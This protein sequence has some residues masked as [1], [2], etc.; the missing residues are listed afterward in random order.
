MPRSWTS[1]ARL[2]LTATRLA[3][4]IARGGLRR[5]VAL[6]ALRGEGLRAAWA[7]H[8]K[9]RRQAEP[10]RRLVLVGLVE[11][12]GDIVAAEPVARYLRRR[13]PESRIVWAVDGRYRELIDSNPHIDEALTVGCLTEWIHLARSGAFDEIVDLQIHG[14]F[15]EQCCITLERP[16]DRRAITLA[17]YYEHGC[18]LSAFCSVGGLPELTEAPRLYI[19]DRVRARVDTLDLPEHFVVIHGR[20][21]QEA[22]NWTAEGWQGLAERLPRERGAAVVEVGLRPVIASPHAGYRS[23]CGQLSLLETAEVIRRA[24]LFIGIDSG[25]AHL[26]NAA[27]TAGV[28]LL[29]EYGP[30]RRYLPY[31]GGYAD[32]SRATILYGDGP[33]STLHVD[34]VLHAVYGRLLAELV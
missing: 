24:D 22:R 28:V 4:D 33:A 12:F 3:L 25:P 27:G 29:G 2:P 10:R 18:L 7:V 13:D 8:A 5:H 26:A 23:L 31:S 19:P 15:C 20:S 16:P 14:R 32:G 17:N 21:N 11:H 9:R 6:A 34:R 1:A 30:F